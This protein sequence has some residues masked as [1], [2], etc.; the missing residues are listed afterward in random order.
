M[1]AHHRGHVLRPHLLVVGLDRRDRRS[2]Q[3]EQVRPDHRHQLRAVG[4]DR[5]RMYRRGERRLERPGRRP[6]LGGRLLGR[7]K[8][9]RSARPHRER[10]PPASPRPT[11]PARAHS[12]RPTP[13]T[14]TRSPP[15]AARRPTHPRHVPP[16]ASAPNPCRRTSA[17]SS[18]RAVVPKNPSARP[19]SIRAASSLGTGPST[20]FIMVF[21]GTPNCSD[22][23]A[24]SVRFAQP[25][26]ALDHEPTPRTGSARRDAMLKVTVAAHKPGPS[27][28][29]GHP[30][31]R[32]CP[33]ARMT[34]YGAS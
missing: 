17:T 14:R 34:E 31:G 1:I 4:R 33:A 10:P 13:P 29:P 25:P 11:D 28:Q 32:R 2:V 22:F 3:P 16:P 8:S 12:S 5:R 27:Q 23:E 6:D 20:E 18:P 19:A 21:R 7:G 9:P 30:P 15:T 24:N 26:R